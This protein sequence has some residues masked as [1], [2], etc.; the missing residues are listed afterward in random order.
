LP[1]TACK[2]LGAFEKLRKAPNSL[3]ISV[4]PSVGLEQLGSHW[5]DF[6]ENI[7]GFLENLSVKS[8]FIKI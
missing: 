4:R 7:S 5:T 3:V 2:F 1:S 8:S 6:H